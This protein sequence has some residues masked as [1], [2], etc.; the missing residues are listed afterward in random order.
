[1]KAWRKIEGEFP[2]PKNRKGRSVSLCGRHVDNRTKDGAANIA[3][4]N[5]VAKV[6][7]PIRIAVT[8]SAFPG[9]R[10][11]SAVIVPRNDRSQD[12]LQRVAGGLVV[13]R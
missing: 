9:L 8:G 1:M 10:L 6:H 3:I 5:E 13:R 7:W 12:V 11:A 2:E 4:E